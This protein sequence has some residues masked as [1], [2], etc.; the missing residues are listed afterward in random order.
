MKEQMKP[1]LLKIAARAFTVAAVAGGIL[2]ASAPGAWAQQTPVAGPAPAKATRDRPMDRVDRVEARIAKLHEKLHIT[3]A[4]EQTWN[5][6][7]QV[8]RDN[9]KAM[10]ALLDQRAQQIKKMD[11]ISELRSHAEMAE[12]HAAGM[13]KLIPAF[14]TLYSSM[15]EDQKKIADKVMTYHEGRR[16]HRG[17]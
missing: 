16:R 11:A 17:K 4:Q 9:A 12:V 8:M 10:K 7:A 2:L 15:P 1:S 13:R 5:D 3:S 6:F 14:E